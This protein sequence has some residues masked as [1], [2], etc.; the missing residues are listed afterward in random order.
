MSESWVTIHQAAQQ[1]GRTTQTVQ[2][3]IKNC[4]LTCIDGHV[5][6]HQLTR[7]EREQRE[8]S[9]GRPAGHNKP[10][11]PKRLTR[12]QHHEIPCEYDPELWFSSHPADIHEAITWCQECPGKETCLILAKRNREYTGIWGGHPIHLGKPVSIQEYL[13]ARA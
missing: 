13:D 6:T 7:I 11:T 10:R 2:R 12:W 4:G 8:R 3:W 1:T 9:G 5:N